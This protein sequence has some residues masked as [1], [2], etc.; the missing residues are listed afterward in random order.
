M[1]GYLD[2]LKGAVS[3]KQAPSALQKL[4]KA[5]YDSFCST[6]GAH[7]SEIEAPGALWGRV[8]IRGPDGRTV[9][10]DS[11]SGYTLTDWQAYAERY[12]GPGCVVTVIAG[13][14]KPR[15]RSTS[16]RRYGPPARA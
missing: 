12:H 5:P 4:Q 9:E 6:Q 10:L 7:V 13:L 3:E 15:D 16:M 8:A 2:R 14:P 11:P 1:M